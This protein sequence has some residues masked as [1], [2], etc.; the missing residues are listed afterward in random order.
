MFFSSRPCYQAKF[1][2]FESSLLLQ[3]NWCHHECGPWTNHISSPS[4]GLLRCSSRTMVLSNNK[5]TISFKYIGTYRKQNYFNIKN[6][7]KVKR[8]LYSPHPAPTHIFHSE[9]MTKVSE[10]CWCGHYFNLI[11]PFNLLAAILRDRQFSQ[12]IT[13]TAPFLILYWMLKIIIIILFLLVIIIIATVIWN[14]HTD[15]VAQV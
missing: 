13:K 9:M 4:W 8:S 10:V 7:K 5:D 3:H 12:W 1:W 2:Y 14:K 15:S 6:A 11:F